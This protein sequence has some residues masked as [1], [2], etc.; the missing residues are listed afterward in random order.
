MQF[1]VIIQGGMGIAVSNWQLARAVSRLGELGVISGTMLAVILARRLQE[2][3]PAGDMRRALEHF[4]IPGVAERLLADHYVPGGKPPGASYM[5]TPMTTLQPG[6]ALTELTV[7]ANFVEVYLA[8]EGHAGPVGIN[9]LEK[10]QLATLPSLYGAMLANVDYVLMGAGIPRQIPGALDN[11]AAGREASLRIDVTG[12]KPG[13]EFQTKLDPA[14]LW[15]QPAPGLSRPKFLAI[16]SSATL[17]LTLAK[18]SNGRVDGFVVEGEVAGGH[19]APPRGPMQLSPAG[20]PVYG[21][22]DVPDLAKIRELGLPF[23]LAGSYARPER[24]AEARS[25]GAAGIQVGTAFAF[26]EESGIEPALKHEAIRASRAAMTRVFTDPLASPTGFPFKVLKVRGTLSEPAVYAARHRICDLG[27]L[28][29]VY[30]RDDG[31]VGY[32]CPAEPV[33]DYVRKGGRI[34]DTVGRKCLCNGLAAT[35][36]LGQLRAGHREQ[37]I[38]TAG[39]EAADLARLLPAGADSYRAEDVIRYLRG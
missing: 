26:C 31:S 12:A 4:P 33:E 29:E 35:V 25:L 23:W 20:E 5:L 39:D 19:N 30:R 36:G 28:R 13:E 24:L 37:P 15:Q 14:A 38:V 7:A 10:I 17:A 9:L 11:F 16:V 2:G 3:D 8:K 1:P 34:E 22:R 21:P 27:G 18:K 32:R 6:R